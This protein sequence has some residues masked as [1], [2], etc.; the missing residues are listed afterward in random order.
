MSCHWTTPQG[1]LER[2]DPRAAALTRPRAGA[3]RSKLLDP[4]HRLLD[5][6]GLHS[7]KYCCSVRGESEI[8]RGAMAPAVAAAALGAHRAGRRARAARRWAPAPARGAASPG[9]GERGGDRRVDRLPHRPRPLAA[10]LPVAGAEPPLAA[11]AGHQDTSMVRRDYFSDVRPSGVTP[12]ALVS[13]TSY[14][15][16]TAA[17]A[18]GEIIAWGTGPDATPAAHLLGLDG[19]T[20]PSRGHPVRRIPGNRRGRHDGRPERRGLPRARRDLHRRVRRPRGRPELRFAGRCAAGRGRLGPASDAGP[21]A[22]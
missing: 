10:H 3:R 19:I 5:T 15:V 4:A 11:V 16:H 1:T 14:S 6:C 12:L 7:C 21:P 13:H 22:R 18:V 2:I 9:A 17:I 8:F 20:R